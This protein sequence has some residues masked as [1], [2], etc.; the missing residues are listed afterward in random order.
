MI[1]KGDFVELDYVGKIKDANEV[2]DLT[3][4]TE[5]KKHH[6]FNEKAAYHPIISCVGERMIVHGVDDFL[7]GKDCATYIVDLQPEQ[8]FGKKDAKLMKMLPLAVFTKKN[9]R[10]FPGL[11]LDFDGHLGTIRSVSGGRV[12]VDFNHPLAGRTLVYELKVRRIVTSE[13]EQLQGF[14]SFL[15]HQD[16]LC[17]VKDHKAIIT[18][19]VPEQ[20]QEAVRKRVHVLI[21][22]IK[23]ITFA[24]PAPPTEKTPVEKKAGEQK[25]IKRFKK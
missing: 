22:G 7:V 3:E 4:A 14:L 6:L 23:D 13:L 16:V 21:P 2:F 24:A 20:L 15:F 17:S 25:Q 19:A 10:P 8:A 1:N 5:A 9:I 12:I 18:L 11:Q